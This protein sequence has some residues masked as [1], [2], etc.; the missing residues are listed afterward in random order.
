M[1][2]YMGPPWLADGHNQLT[3]WQLY[4]AMDGVCPED[5]HGHWTIV[6]LF[7][8]LWAHLLPDLDPGHFSFSWPRGGE[9]TR[10]LLHPTSPRG[11][12]EIDG[13]PMTFSIPVDSVAQGQ[14]AAAGG[15]AHFPRGA[16]I[17]AD[18]GGRTSSH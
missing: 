6:L 7:V 1:R 12:G 13:D 11:S 14:L 5:G 8:L 17:M 10:A 3:P 9:V 18:P 16:S 2:L 4:A 15:W